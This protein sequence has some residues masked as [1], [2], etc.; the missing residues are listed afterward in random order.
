MLR[1]PMRLKLYVVHGSHPCAAVEKA[2]SLKGLDYRVVE[3]PPPLQV[4]DAEVIFGGRTVPGLRIDGE[5]KV[6]GS[7]AI[8]RRLDQLAPGAP[9]LPRRSGAARRDRGSRALGR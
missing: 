5:E 9:L 7:R 4:L 6:H 1:V 2:L 8:M 3:W